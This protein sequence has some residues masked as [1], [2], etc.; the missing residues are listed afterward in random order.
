MAKVETI[1]IDSNKPTNS[2]IEEYRHLVSE[3]KREIRFMDEKYGENWDNVAK[4]DYLRL[5]SLEEKL[6]KIQAKYPNYNFKNNEN[7]GKNRM[8]NENRN[9]EFLRQ[10][11][12]EKEIN[13]TNIEVRAT[14]TQYA[15]VENNSQVEVPQ[16]LV[17]GILMEAQRQNELFNRVH[18]IHTS[19]NTKLNVGSYQQMELAQLDEFEEISMQDFS[20]SHCEI[21]MN[22]YGTGSRL[23]RRLIQASNFDV[24]QHCCLLFGDRLGLTCEKEVV[25]VLQANNKVQKVGYLADDVYETPLNALVKGLLKLKPVDRAQAVCVCSPDYFEKCVLQQ[26]GNGRNQLSYSLDGVR[27]S[28]MGVPVVVS[29]ALETGAYIGNFGRAV[30]ACVNIEHIKAVDMPNVHAVDIFLNAYFGVAV[31]MPEAVVRIEFQA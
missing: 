19:Q 27:P 29:D 23:S 10:L 5:T 1:L 15:P 13:M 21:V 2:E 9:Q 7:G 31:Q 12:E 28:I 3:M 25:R 4:S 6:D 24:M 30:V 16:N 17:K 11:K 18:M 20:V 26:D 22:R 8:K 14:G